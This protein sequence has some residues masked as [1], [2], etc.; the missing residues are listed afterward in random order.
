MPSATTNQQVLRPSI[1]ATY[2]DRDTPRSC[3]YKSDKMNGDIANKERKHA[4]ANNHG[5]LKTEAGAPVPEAADLL[6][7]KGRG[8]GWAACRAS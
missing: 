8:E 3:A 4:K 6:T 1:F 5:R 2:K 7:S